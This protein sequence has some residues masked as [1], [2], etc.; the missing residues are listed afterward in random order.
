MSHYYS[1]LLT[2]G[3]LN[4]AFGDKFLNRLESRKRRG[5]IAHRNCRLRNYEYPELI[6]QTDYNQSIN[7]HLQQ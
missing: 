6:N 4:I 3:H 2:L 1:V 5:K 7:Q